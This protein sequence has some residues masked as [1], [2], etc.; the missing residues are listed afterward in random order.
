[1]P[2]RFRRFLTPSIFLALTAAP[3][4][5]DALDYLDG[6]FFASAGLCDALERDGMAA[7]DNTEGEVLTGGDLGAFH[8]PQYPG[9]CRIDG[10]VNPQLFGRGSD[11]PTAMV[12]VSCIDDVAVPDFGIFALEYW[13][14]E[15]G[16][17]A[18]VT[19]YPVAAGALD[20]LVGDYSECSGRPAKLLAELFSE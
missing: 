15:N 1:M 18:R 14:P 8:I 2:R 19:V 4:F 6:R 5:A 10:I 7:V 12:T 20:H 3:A 9:I 11:L 13:P 16:N 17:I